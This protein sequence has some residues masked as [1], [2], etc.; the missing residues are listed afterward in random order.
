ML[1][2]VGAVLLLSCGTLYNKRRM[3]RG[4]SNLSKRL[5]EQALKRKQSN[6]R[7]L[8]DMV[9]DPL[10]SKQMER[11]ISN[12]INNTDTNITVA[13]RME[14]IRTRANQPVTH[15]DV[16]IS[17]EDISSA[18]IIHTWL[19]LLLLFGTVAFCF[20]WEDTIFIWVG[21]VLVELVDDMMVFSR[22]K[23]TGICQPSSQRN[24]HDD[25][26][27]AYTV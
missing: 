20:L 25:D 15:D 19:L 18:A 13:E 6:R 3:A 8:R 11:G 12:C 22:R 7:R 5:K 16:N 4:G 2:L 26:D 17:A 9:N 24:D 27:L 14:E 10:L 1:H 23:I 21:L